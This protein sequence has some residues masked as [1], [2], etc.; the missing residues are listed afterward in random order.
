MSMGKKKWQVIDDGEIIHVVPDT[1][2]APHG[3][4]VGGVADLADM[5][6]PCSPRIDASSKKLLVIHNSFEDQ[7]MIED[8]LKKIGIEKTT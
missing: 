3:F 4:P 5:D 2:I 8:S 7:K 6:C 1:D